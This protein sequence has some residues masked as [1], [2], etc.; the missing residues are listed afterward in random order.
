MRLQLVSILYRKRGSNFALVL[1]MEPQVEF[2][3]SYSLGAPKFPQGEGGGAEVV[4][5]VRNDPRRWEALE[6]EHRKRG[7]NDALWIK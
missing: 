5:G 6:N 1:Q 3:S 4:S 2:C 7:S